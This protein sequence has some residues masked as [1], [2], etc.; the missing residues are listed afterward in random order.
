MTITEKKLFLQ[1]QLVP[2]LRSLKPET[3]GNWG[4]MNAHQ[5][6]EHLTGA[7]KLHNGTLVLPVVNSGERLEKMRQSLHTEIPFA[8][9]VKNPILQDDPYP[10]R[11]AT[12]DA[13]IDKLQEELNFFFTTFEQNPQLITTNPLFGA[14]N[15]EE[16]ILLLYKHATHHLNQFG[17]L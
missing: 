7:I 2:L 5:M 14:L 4:K 9:N 3:T 17:L 6:V 16:N 11:K 1:T 10:V 12:I 8:P 15:A 13:S